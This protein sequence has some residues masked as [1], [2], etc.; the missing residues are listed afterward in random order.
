MNLTTIEKEK[1]T[2]LIKSLGKLPQI[3]F[4][5]SDI[6]LG[7]KEIPKNVLIRN[8]YPQLNILCNPNTKLFITNGGA[9]SIQEAAHCGLPILGI[10]IFPEN[11]LLIRS[12]VSK[13]AG[14]KIDYADLI[15]ESIIDETLNELLTNNSYKTSAQKLSILFNDRPIKPL[16]NAIYWIEYILK[17]GGAPQLRSRAIDT[18]WF[19]YYML[20]IAIV[21]AILAILLMFLMVNILEFLQNYFDAPLEQR[22]ENHKKQQ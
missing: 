8:W 19:E 13:G 1:L 12:Y 20:D 14:I 2:S 4:I 17:Y 7:L 3:V 9:L 21:F 11:E 10:P 5:K 6:N 15:N 18:I 22:T 16:D